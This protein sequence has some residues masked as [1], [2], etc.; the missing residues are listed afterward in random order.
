MALP[1]TFPYLSN[2]SI[3][4]P[5]VTIPGN[6]SRMC[7][8]SDSVIDDNEDEDDK[9]FVLEIVEVDPDDPRVNVTDGTT[10]VIIVDNDGKL[11]TS[12]N[13]KGARY[14]YCSVVL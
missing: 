14:S 6:A 7:F 2:N 1:H 8:T 13:L 4:F 9:T 10:T 12:S 5:S 11:I 3:F